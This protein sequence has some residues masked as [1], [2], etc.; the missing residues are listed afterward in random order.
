MFLTI[1]LRDES[2]GRLDDS[3]LV[4][5]ERDLPSFDD[6][7]F[8]YL[9][10]FDPYGNTVLSEYQLQDAVLAELEA[11]ASERP[12]AGIELLLA[13]ARTCLQQHRVALWLFGD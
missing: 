1:Q 6:L 5:E 4:I 10:L 8:P 9:R 11:F 2:G 3:L 7:R 13:T 12:S